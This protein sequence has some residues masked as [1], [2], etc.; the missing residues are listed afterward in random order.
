LFKLSDLSD[1]EEE[2]VD[3]LKKEIK[4]PPLSE[5]SAGMLNLWINLS[6]I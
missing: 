1:D 4:A 5:A 2:E 3:L 6:G